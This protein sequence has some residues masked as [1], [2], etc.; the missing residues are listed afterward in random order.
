MSKQH[1]WVAVLPG[2]TVLACGMAYPADELAAVRQLL[3]AGDESPLAVAATGPTAVGGSVVFDDQFGGSE[4]PPGWEVRDPADAGS[5]SLTANPGH[6]RYVVDAQHTSFDGGPAATQDE[7]YRKALHLVRPFAG[8]D[9][10]LTTRLTYGPRPGEPTNNRNMN[11]IIQTRVP[12][13]RE[14]VTISRSVGE[15]GGNPGSNSL[16]LGIAGA[17][18]S[19]PFANTQGPLPPETWSIRVE[20]HGDRFAIRASRDDDGS[21]PEYRLEHACQ[22]GVFAAE[23]EVIIEADG[24]YGSNDPPG[25]MDFAFIAVAEPPIPAVVT[26]DPDRLR[27]GAAGRR[28]VV[29]VQLSAGQPLEDVDHATVLLQA[30]GRPGLAARPVDAV[31]ADYDADGT[32]HLAV[33]FDRRDVEALLAPGSVELTLAGQVLGR[34]F[35]GSYTV[36]VLPPRVD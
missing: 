18:L 25:Y 32:P 9:W 23:Q 21:A 13:R 1:R 19:L 6:L 4:L 31:V 17:S 14:R 30:K 7:P 24:W 20:R 22:P 33:T 29:Y 8:Q 11:L 27:L 28:V 36:R 34:R 12:G 10:V 3:P 26:I 5:Y 16:S 2:L 15:F 35:E